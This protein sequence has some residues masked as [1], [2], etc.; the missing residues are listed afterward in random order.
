MGTAIGLLLTLVI[1]GYSAFV[2]THIRVDFPISAEYVDPADLAKGNWRAVVSDAMHTL[3]PGAQTPAETRD[4]AQIL[5]R[6]TQFFVRNAAVADPSVIG[7]KLTLDVPAADISDQP[8]KGN[9]S[10]GTPEEN[11]RVND[12]QIAWF[13]TLVENGRISTPSTG[14]CSSTPTAAFPKSPAC[15]APLSA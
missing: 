14:A 9:I 12:Q 5:T 2:Q 3:V 10:R 1:G 13:D 4:I 6:N 8:N 11:R 15:R 7:G